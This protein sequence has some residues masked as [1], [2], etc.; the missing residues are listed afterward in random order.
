MFRTSLLYPILDASFL[1]IENRESFLCKLASDLL[2]AGVTLLQYRN[3]EGSARRQLEDAC[4][5][6]EVLP[7][8]RVQL[9]F[10]DRADLAVIAGF[11]GVHVG[12]TDLSPDGARRVVGESGVVGISTHNEEQLRKAIDSPADYVAIGPVFTTNSKQNPDP[13]V[14]QEGVKLARSL[15]SKPLVAIGGI[16]LTNAGQVLAA[17][18]DS[19]AVISCVFSSP[20]PA[21]I[22]RD[23]LQ[24]SGRTFNK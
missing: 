8:G 24:L 16:N 14:G 17:G 4:I 11:D 3:K 5:L 13:V 23:F 19:V 10:N 9:I 7:A 12:Q 20:D 15:T 6:R 2:D 22:V 21:K 18:A 1:P